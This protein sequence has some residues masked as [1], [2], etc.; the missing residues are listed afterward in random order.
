MTSQG[1]GFDADCYT[2]E[3]LYVQEGGT[4]FNQKIF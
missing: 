1:F 2:S 4:G 3:L